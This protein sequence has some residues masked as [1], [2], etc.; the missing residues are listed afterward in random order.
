MKK[1]K[2]NTRRFKEKKNARQQHGP[3]GGYMAPARYTARIPIAEMLLTDAHEGRGEGRGAAEEMTVR[4]MTRGDVRLE[5]R[6]G[7]IYLCRRERSMGTID[8][9]RVLAEAVGRE[10]A[11]VRR[12]IERVHQ[13][14]IGV[15]YMGKSGFYLEP[16]ECHLPASIEID[17]DPEGAGEGDIVCAEVVRWEHEGGLLCRVDGVIGSFDKPSAVLDALVASSHLR[18]VFPA[19]ALDEAERLRPADLAQDPDREDLRGL[20][21]FTIDG[22][23]ARDFDDAVSLEQTEGGGLRLGVHIADVGYYVPQGSALDREAYQRGTS[24]YFPGRVLPMLP[25]QLSNGVCSLR[26]QEDKFTLSALIDLTRDGVV[27]GMRLARTITRS[28]ARLVY[29]DVNALFAGD[30]VQRERM[31]AFHPGITDA[32]LQMQTLSRAI[33][34]R[35]QAQGC[36]DFETEEPKFILDD[37]GEPVE[38][39]L[40]E[41][42]EA[43]MMIEDFMLT[44]NE[45]VARLARERRIPVLYRVHERPDPEKLQLFREFLGGIGVNARGLGRGAKPGD[46]RAVLE[47]CRDREEFDV[48]AT[49]ALRSMQKAR[50]D[51][52]PLGHFGLAMQDYCHFTSPIRRYPDLVVSRAMTSMLAGERAPLRG[53]A[54]A[55]A[56][57]RSSECERAAAEAE[58]MADRLMTAR[59]MASHLGETYCG[60]VS[61]VSEWGMYV[62]LS[63]GAE[64]LVHVRT[65]EDW[66]VFDERRMTLRGERTGAVFSLGQTLDVRVESVEMTSGQ[67]DLSL[68]GP[69]RRE[70]ENAVRS[71]KKRER[72]RMRG[73]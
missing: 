40:R 21:S 62:S 31:N 59:Y 25:E 58:R 41:R 27:T 71:E 64:G 7:T 46:I 29:D 5:A 28:D 6:D 24:V 55:D 56:A 26:P 2:Q 53:D 1:K 66:F 60:R 37:D 42:G 44:A 68:T 73:Y 65:L 9:D 72:A 17:G 4:G 70:G 51:A 67:I 16:M 43:E 32:L 30:A 11:V 54:L 20:L 34:A 3:A 13:S 15:V 63:N 14:V 8:G 33:R 50:Y 12:V 36:I 52:Q 45:C 47:G 10:R 49:L 61:G 38:I 22:R 18:S 69:L 19:Q 39:I 35:R 48:I 57:M 23:D